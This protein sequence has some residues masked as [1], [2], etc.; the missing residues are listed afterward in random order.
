[1]FEITTGLSAPCIRQLNTTWSLV[2][3][4]SLEKYQCLQQVCSP[5]D[6][7]RS[8]RQAFALAE[9]QPR[10]AC[11][12]ILVKDLFTYEEAMKSMEDGLVN[13][14][15]FRKIYRVISEAL[16]RQNFNY[17]PAGAGANGAGVGTANNVGGVSR[18]GRGILRPD[19]KTQIHIR[20][21]IDTYVVVPRVFLLAGLS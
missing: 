18:K 17:V 16:D 12:F 8:Y 6:N 21:R 2:G 19:R 3:A 14:Q 5:D 13:W 11:W 20:H 9:G 7:Y 1:L 10:L 15:K 4:A